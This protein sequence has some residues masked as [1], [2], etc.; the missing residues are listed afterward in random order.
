M[1]PEYGTVEEA[2]DCYQ[3][4]DRSRL[5]ADVRDWFATYFQYCADKDELEKVEK[6]LD[7]A[8]NGAIP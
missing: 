6:E 1:L 8:V 4:F 7:Q 5:P 2:K 3:K